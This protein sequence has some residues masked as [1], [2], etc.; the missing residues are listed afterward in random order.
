MKLRF[1]NLQ[2]SKTEKPPD[3]GSQTKSVLT[4]L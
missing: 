2:A 4:N 3:A 1:D